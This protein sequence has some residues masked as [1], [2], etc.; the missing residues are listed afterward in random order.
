MRHFG[1]LSNTVND[2][3]K[4][5]LSATLIHYAMHHMQNDLTCMCTKY[6]TS[7]AEMDY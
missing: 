3:L 7:G 1:L 5:I 6:T 2:I 4:L